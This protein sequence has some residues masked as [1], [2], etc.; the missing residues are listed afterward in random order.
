MGPYERHSYYSRPY[1]HTWP[2]QA[3]TH[4][5]GRGRKVHAIRFKAK[6]V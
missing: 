1:V 6:H 5:K 4:Y 2:G 3:R